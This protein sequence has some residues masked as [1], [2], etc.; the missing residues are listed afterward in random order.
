VL[1]GKVALVLGAEG[2]GLSN[3]ALAAA[4]HRVRVPMAEDVDSL[5]VA[6]AFGVVAAFAA[7]R[8]GWA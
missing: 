3:N 1:D 4:A 5:N 7:S 8:A 2:P 6:T